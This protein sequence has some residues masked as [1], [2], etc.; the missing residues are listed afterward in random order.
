MGVNAYITHGLSKTRIYG[1]WKKMIYRCENPK[2]AEFKHYGGRGIKVCKEWHD[3]KNFYNWAINNG[4]GERLE[5]D[6][7]DNSK[8]YCPENCRWATRKQQCNNERRNVRTEI[9][10][11][12]HTLAEW[13]EITGINANTLQYRYYRG[14]RGERLIRK[15]D[16]ENY[17]LG[18]KTTSNTGIRGISKNKNGI[19]QVDVFHKKKRYSASAKTLEEAI[20][21]KEEILNQLN[22]E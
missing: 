14:D 13:S 6:R 17:D 22:K 21:K 2:V 18:R 20:K 8:D 3:I 11:V 4:Y 15:V 16:L 5:I 1:I 9:N 12:T 19:F 10:G 7:I